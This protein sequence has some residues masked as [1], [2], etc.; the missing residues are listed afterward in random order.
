MPGSSAGDTPVATPAERSY[1]HVES[2]V[3]DTWRD[4]L[5]IAQVAPNDSFF[6]LGG[7]SLIATQACA[8]IGLA[9]GVE[10]PLR[11]FFDCDT[12]RRQSEAILEKLTVGQPS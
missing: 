4:V 10:V 9:L 12:L 8:R 6:D 11:M 2:V 3:A 7:D 5:G 1:S